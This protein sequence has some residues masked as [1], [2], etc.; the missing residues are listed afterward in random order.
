MI[1]DAYD[2]N[3]V[4]P[5]K[6]ELLMVEQV[7]ALCAACHLRIGLIAENNY[8]KPA[9]VSELFMATMRTKL[10]DYWENNE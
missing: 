10:D 4:T 9:T 6:K 7:D 3:A 5:K 1:I 8:V 2:R